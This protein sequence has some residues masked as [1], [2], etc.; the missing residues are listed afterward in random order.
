M[1]LFSLA[2]KINAENTQFEE[3]TDFDKSEST[4]TNAIGTIVNQ[5]S[6]CKYVQ[7]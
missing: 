1:C 2:I 7:Q 5:N 3:K 4:T 6:Y